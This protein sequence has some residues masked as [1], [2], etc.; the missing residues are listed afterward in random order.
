MLNQMQMT[1]NMTSLETAWPANINN[2]GLNEQN[3]KSRICFL[4]TFGTKS[5]LK[6]TKTT[7]QLLKMSALVQ[8]KKRVIEWS[9]LETT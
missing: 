1:S 2:V 9:V 4:F 7:K 5:K 8:P 3:H 6:L